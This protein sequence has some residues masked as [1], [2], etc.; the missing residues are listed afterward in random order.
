MSPL[1]REGKRPLSWDPTSTL[2]G[3]AVERERA[4]WKRTTTRLREP[5]RPSGFRMCACVRGVCMLAATGQTLP[6]GQCGR[7]TGF[8]TVALGDRD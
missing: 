1:G 3:F 6:Q 4:I 2:Q 5:P 8:E 7:E